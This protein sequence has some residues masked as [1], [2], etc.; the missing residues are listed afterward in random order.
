MPQLVLFNEVFDDG[1]FEFLGEVPHV[2]RDPHDFGCSRSIARIFNGATTSRADTAF[3]RLTR[4]SHVDADNIMAG[5]DRFRC[6][7]S[8]IHASGKCG[9][10][11]HSIVLSVGSTVHAVSTVRV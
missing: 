5:L 11:T 8:R 10:N 2:E 7:D 4:Q 3:L 1:F 6:S 9:K